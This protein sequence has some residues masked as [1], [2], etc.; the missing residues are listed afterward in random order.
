VREDKVAKYLFVYY[1]GKMETDPK[2]AEKSMAAWNKWFGGLG[3]AV[4]DGGSPTLPGKIVAASGVK[5]VTAK[6]VTG[7]S[8]LQANSLDAA[9]AMAKTCP[10]IADGGQ[11]A[12]YEL[13][14][15][16]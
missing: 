10:I 15:V 6:P 14:P 13:L 16:M 7:Y 3:K 4:V 2:M 5:N 9:V 11:V 1:G 12:V 8:I